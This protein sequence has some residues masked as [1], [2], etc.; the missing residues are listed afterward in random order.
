RVDHGNADAVQAAGYLVGILVE[1][2]TRMQ[3]GHDDL[4]RGNPLAFVDVD[5]NAAAVVAHG[6]GAVGIEHDLYRGG[7]PGQCFVDGI[8]DHLVDHVV[9]AG[10]VVGVAGIHAR[11]LAHGVQALQTPDRFRAVLN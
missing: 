6:D 10:A 1:F 8:V 4:G 7:I 3:L 9:Q 5:R 2:S 11:P